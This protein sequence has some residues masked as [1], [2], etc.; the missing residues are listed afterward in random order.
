[1]A[2]HFTEAIERQT[3][4]RRR[5]FRVAKRARKRRRGYLRRREWAKARQARRV[6]I[7]ANREARAALKRA[8]VLRSARKKANIVA[9]LARHRRSAGRTADGRKL[10]WF[11][12]RPV[13]AELYPHLV[14][15]RKHGW[16]G[17]VTSGYRSPTYSR[18][19]C[20][21]MCGAPSCPGRCAGIA[22]NHVRAAIDVSDYV[23]FGRLMRSYPG[24]PRIFNA[25][26]ARDPVHFSPSGR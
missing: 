17:V 16:K 11:T 13:V 2:D 14:W 8:R 5:A 10:Y 18:S 12:G 20:Y 4:R 24:S 1:M 26:G 22:S 23:T 9:R 3:K 19:L 15:A 6:A 21:A 7:R 25:L